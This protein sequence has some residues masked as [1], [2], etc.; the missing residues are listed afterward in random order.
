MA[1]S[2]EPKRDNLPAHYIASLD[3][4]LPAYMRSLLLDYSHIPEDEME[5]HMYA[6][7]DKLWKT[8][9]YPC[10]GYWS[11]LTTNLTAA[12]D[13]DVIL[14]KAKAGERV[15]DMGTCVGQELRVL[16]N[17]G[18][19]SDNMYG[20]DITNKFWPIGFE[21][22][23]DSATFHATFIESDVFDTS[24]ELMEKLQNSCEVIYLGLFLHLFSYELQVEASCNIVR[25]SKGPGS[26]IAG[27]SGGWNKAGVQPRTL[28]IQREG[29]NDKPFRFRQDKESFTKMWQEVSAMTK[30]KWDV[31]V[32]NKPDELAWRH[33]GEGLADGIRPEWIFFT[34]T[35]TA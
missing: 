23:R 14:Q 3:G 20:A 33:S 24:S 8:A 5:A 25:L 18:T 22:F 16:V 32:E 6:V 21:L 34:L 19:P 4:C 31:H 2:E 13:Y 9:P 11:Y 15:L 28:G 29:K 26:I 35:R 17:E 30:T 12:K 1:E 10:V 27:K 7:R